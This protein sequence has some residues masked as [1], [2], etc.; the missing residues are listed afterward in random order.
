M[1]KE[2]IELTTEELWKVLE[3]VTLQTKRGVIGLDDAEKHA[4]GIFEMLEEKR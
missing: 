1:T 3:F 4:C 2:R